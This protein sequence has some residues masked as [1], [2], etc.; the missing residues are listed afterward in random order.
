ME[1]PGPSS[2]SLGLSRGLSKTGL[3]LPISSLAPDILRSNHFGKWLVVIGNDSRC[4][5][6][7]HTPYYARRSGSEPQG[8][9]AGITSE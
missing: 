4:M 3:A 9:A 2:L 8:N 1:L 7:E 5:I 6:C